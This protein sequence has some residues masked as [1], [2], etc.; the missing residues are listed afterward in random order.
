MDLENYDDSIEKSILSCILIKPSLLNECYL[1]PKHFFKNKKL[2][3]FF[4]KFYRQYY[5]LD[6]TIM[7]S[8]VRNKSEFLDRCFD[9]VTRE[10]S[11]LLFYDYQE[12]Q[13]EIYKAF[14][15]NQIINKFNLKEIDYT[16]MIDEINKINNEFIKTNDKSKLS[17][18]EIFELITTDKSL[19]QFDEYTS[20]Q[21]KINFLQ[22]TVNVI[23]ARTS[24]GKSGLALNILND[25]SKNYKCL[26]F[27]MEMT[28]KEIYQRL[29]SMNS[30]VPIEYFTKP[31]DYQIEL[32]KKASKDIYQR[33]M[34]VINGSKS[35]KALKKIIIKEQ[36]EEHLIVFID[37]IGYVYTKSTHNDRERIGE[38]VRELQILSKDYN[39]T[40]FILAQINR[41]GNT[42]PTLV[43]LKDSGELEQTAH[44][45]LILHNPNSD[46]N[47]ESPVLKL[48][49]PKNRNGKT[50]YIQMQYEKKIQKFKEV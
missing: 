38:A 50:G 27:N 35:I 49:I 17:P 26:Y 46:L 11:A 18:D 23:A 40:L 45:V 48:M 33:K 8:H 10:P 9:L 7:S 32:I 37:Y 2:Y 14:T 4:Q 30:R 22:N 39:I 5:N 36:K 20:L 6:F 13:E 28:E 31:T 16:T 19:L 34:R 24:V 1:E 12:K 21:N 44:V 29:V 42:E 15:I 3:D 25:L 47:E 43:N 41:E